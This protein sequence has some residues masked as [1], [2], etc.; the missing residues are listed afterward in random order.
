MFIYQLILYL[1]R[2][3]FFD[4]FRQLA[5]TGYAIEM[6][7]THHFSQHTR[8]MQINH[9]QITTEYTVGYVRVFQHPTQTLNHQHAFGNFCGRLRQGIH[10]IHRRRCKFNTRLFQL[11]VRRT[12]AVQ[13]WIHRT[14]TATDIKACQ[15]SLGMPESY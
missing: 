5:D 8:K 7:H 12:P 6:H 10:L 3:D 11:Q 2:I 9:Q 13:Q 15:R 4:T 1:Q 14:K